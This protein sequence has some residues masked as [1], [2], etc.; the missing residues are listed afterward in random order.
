MTYSTYV[1]VNNL[2]F[3]ESPRWHQD[4]FWFADQFTGDVLTLS[5]DGRVE[6]VTTLPDH[7]G[8]LD[9]L[10]DGTLLAVGMT[11]RLVHRLGPQGLEVYANLSGLAAFHCNDLLV[12]AFARCRNRVS[13]RQRQ[14][15]FFDG[16][17]KIR[18]VR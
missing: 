17:L 7:V 10:P 9:W 3:P 8:G 6:I 2:V 13:A 11:E 14:R 18:R 4:R 5:L 12:D 16:L 1:V 15:N